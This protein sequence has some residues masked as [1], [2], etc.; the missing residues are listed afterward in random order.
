MTA[1]ISFSRQNDTGSH[2]R[3][4]LCLLA[5]KTRSR[6]RTHLKVSYNTQY[7]C[8]GKILSKLYK[9]VNGPKKK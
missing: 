9:A 8:I 6:T 5:G 1:A 3:T 2:A 7:Y 4:P